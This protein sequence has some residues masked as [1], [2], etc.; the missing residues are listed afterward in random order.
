MFALLARLA[1]GHARRVLIVAAIV[2]VAAGLGGRSVAD[3]LDP[4]GADDPSTESVHADKLLENAGNRETSVVALIN[5]APVSVPATR[6]RVEG[7]ERELRARPDVAWVAGYYDTR[8]RDFVSRAGDATYVAVGLRP[9][10]DKAVQDAGKAIEA[11]L[12][13]RHGVEVG[14]SA[15]VAA[16]VNK[17]VQHDL[18]RAELLAFPL[19]LVLS[20][21]FFR[22]LVAALLPLLV[23]GLTIV[24]T[25]LLL[26]AAA[27]VTSIS[28]FALNLVTGLGLGLAIDYSLFV[29]SRYREEILKDGPG[30]AA[31]KRTIGTAG[32]TVL[33][34][35]LTVAVALTSLT[36]FPQRFLYSMGIGGALVALLSATVALTVL[37]AVLTLLGSRVNAL[38]PRFLQRRASREARAAEAGFWWRLSQLVMRRPAPI[39]TV[40]ALGLIVAGLPFLGIKFNQPDA[41][42]LPQS[43]SARQVD[44]V[45]RSQFP[46]FRDSPIRVAVEGG[47]QAVARV[48]DQLRSVP[49]IAAV[50]PP[51]RLTGGVT[52][53]EAI[54]THAQLSDETQVTVKRVRA[55]AEPPGAQVLVTGGA[56][57]FVDLQESL[58]DHLPIAIAIAVVA[59]FVILFL[60]T[61]S[62]V[63]P[64]VSLLMNVLN[65]SAVFGLLVLIFQDGRFESLL[66]YTS[67]GA[68]EQTMPL[69]IFAVAFGLSTDYGVFLL[70]RIKEARDAGAGD[71][72]AVAIG[73]ERTGRIVTA[74]ALLFAV[75]IGAFATSE[76]VFIKQNGV[77]TAL[78]VLIDA[79]IIRALLVP[80]LLAMLGRWSWWSPQPLRRLHHRI[81]LSEAGSAPA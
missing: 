50:N 37:P 55:L 41:Q 74:A 4:Y 48:S 80:S 10:G 69:L 40:A 29:V 51:R 1:D 58:Q 62:V 14:G 45:L 56:A 44:N 26:R 77:G 20:L 35:S 6:K 27:D 21:L 19:L 70:S 36:V 67:Q 5:G 9:T 42:V 2:F 79:T 17:Q 68:I 57:H 78:A 30:L 38:A 43:A 52:A 7:I 33:F 31:M 47:P 46:P 71:A 13:R 32:R 3:K 11:Q 34:S 64:V 73:L 25:F 12:A 59:T 16:Q 28:I 66:G 53:I 63:L 22:S 49:G 65:L 60:L 23:G 76:I 72:E 54:T 15:V 81:G 39:A 18:S 24:G 75:A 8:N 61:G